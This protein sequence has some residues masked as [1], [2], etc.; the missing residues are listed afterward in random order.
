MEQ[1]DNST[2]SF[3][4]TQKKYSLVLIVQTPRVYMEGA[5]GGEREGKIR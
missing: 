3:E 1:L 2:T 5:S 4:V